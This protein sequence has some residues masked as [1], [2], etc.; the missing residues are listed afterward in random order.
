MMANFLDHN[1]IDTG[2]TKAEF[3]QQLHPAIKYEAQRR[4][5]EAAPEW[6]QRNAAIDLQSSDADVRAAGQAVIDAVNAIR[7]KSNEIE[8]GLTAKSDVEILAFNARDDAHWT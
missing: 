8:A 5:L 2:Q 7:A 3:C 4:I 1:G 6:R